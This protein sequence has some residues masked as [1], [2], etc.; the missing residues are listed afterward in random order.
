M[1]DSEIK[2]LEQELNALKK[3]TSAEE[4]RET[5]DVQK[6]PEGTIEQI[7]KR[8]GWNL[9]TKS[10]IEVKRSSACAICGT[11]RRQEVKE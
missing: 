3:K 9:L 2:K 5:V 7:A 1:S 8:N 6:V 4:T 11:I 10:P